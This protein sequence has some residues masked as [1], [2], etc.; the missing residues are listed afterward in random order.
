M[1]RTASHD[2]HLI[3]GPVHLTKYSETVRRGITLVL[4]EERG[5]GDGKGAVTLYVIIIVFTPFSVFEGWTLS[6][7][8]PESPF[9]GELLD[10]QKGVFVI[11]PDN[12]GQAIAG[13]LARVLAH[14]GACCSM[15]LRVR[16]STPDIHNTIT[17]K[18]QTHVLDHC[19]I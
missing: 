9:P 6:C 3:E 8:L 16:G 11:M 18:C 19:G 12:T 7:L 15:G 2:M 4:V 10:Y 1:N 5:R 14:V 13:F 17:K